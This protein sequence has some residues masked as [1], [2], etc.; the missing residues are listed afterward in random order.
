MSQ[1]GVSGGIIWGED[2][3]KRDPIADT[4]TRNVTWLRHRTEG[5]SWYFS[6]IEICG[7]FFCGTKA[8][9]SGDIVL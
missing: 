3:M 7:I 5:S 4:K 1:G 9:K 6:E 2:S 8:F